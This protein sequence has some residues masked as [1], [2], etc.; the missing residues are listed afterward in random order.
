MSV[1][2]PTCS[3]MTTPTTRRTMSIV[4]VELLVLVQPVLLSRSSPLRTPSRPVISCRFLQSPSNRLTLA[5]MRCAAT[6]AAEAVAVA[7]EVAA[8]EVEAA[9]VV[10]VVVAGAEATLTPFATAAGKLLTTT[11]FA[12]R[13][14][15]FTAHSHG[16]HDR[17]FF[18]SGSLHSFL[19]CA[20][21][22]QE[23]S[24]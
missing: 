13:S 9:V 16:V 19:S 4:L 15:S 10:A 6:V 23:F 18:R 17:H 1:T 24:T 5:Y 21:R 12:T 22:A 20:T 14:R 11:S 7:G 8:A 3:T 2:L